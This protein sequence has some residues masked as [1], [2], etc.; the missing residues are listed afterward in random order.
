MHDDADQ[1]IANIKKMRGG[2]QAKGANGKEKPI[3]WP[4]PTELPKGLVPVLPFKAE[5]LP[6][7]IAP[8]VMDVSDRCPWIAGW[9]PV[10]RASRAKRHM[11]GGCEPVGGHRGAI[12]II[13]N[14]GNAGSDQATLPLRQPGV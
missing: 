7:P 1:I 10:R 13:E 5:Y 4:E 9:P 2:D 3:V 14:A 6:E 12:R 8:W 11:D